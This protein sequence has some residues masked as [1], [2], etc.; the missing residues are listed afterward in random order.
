MSEHLGPLLPLRPRPCARFVDGQ[1]DLKDLAL[2]RP[3]RHH[4]LILDTRWP[5]HE[6]SLAATRTR[7]HL[8]PH[9][10]RA[11]H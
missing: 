3:L 5:L 7:W 4:H 9:Q 10:R 6:H 8:Q 2:C 11:T 1:L